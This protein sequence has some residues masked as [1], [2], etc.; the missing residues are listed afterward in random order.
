LPIGGPSSLDSRLHSLRR[1]FHI[2]A[3][4]RIVRLRGRFQERTARCGMF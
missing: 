2:E 3:D 4:A 1:H